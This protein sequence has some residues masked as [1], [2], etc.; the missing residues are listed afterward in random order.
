[1]QHHLAPQNSLTFK[2]FFLPVLK[3]TSWI[4]R[5]ANLRKKEEWLF[6]QVQDCTQ[7]NKRATEKTGQTVCMV[8]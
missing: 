7:H 6:S 2:Y 5:I 1:M 4:W 8:C 3:L